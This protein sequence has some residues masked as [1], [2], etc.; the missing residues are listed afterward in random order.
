MKSALRIAAVWLLAAPLM[1]HEGHG[2]PGQGHTASHDLTEPMHLLSGALL[3]A[4][5]AGLSL[6]AWR[7]LR[8]FP[9]GVRQVGQ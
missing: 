3:L 1:A 9:G 6:V 4:A 5:M 7:Y 8:S 2:T